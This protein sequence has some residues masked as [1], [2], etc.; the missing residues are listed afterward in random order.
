M[1]LLP[2]DYAVRNLGRSTPRLVAIASGSALV[3]LLIVGAAAFARGMNRSLTVSRDNA[4]ILLLSS[5]SEESLERSQ[6][7]PAV[8]G[9]AAAGIPGIREALGIPLVSPE[10]H[11]AMI[12]RRERESLEELRALFRGVTPTA[13]LVHP[14][15]Q[16]VEGSPPRPGQQELLVG[17]LASAKMGVP[18]ADLA[19]GRQ[20]WFDDRPWTVAGRFRAPGTV[21]DAEIWLPLADLQVA[22]QNDKLSVVVATLGEGAEF[23]DADAW[24]K[25]RLDLELSALSEA[26]Y[27]ASLRRFY[28]PVQ[29]MVWATATLMALAGLLG[30]LNTLY[31]AFA[32]RTRELGTLQ[33][34]GFPR[35]A[36]LLSLVQ[37]SL[38]ATGAG[39]L[40]GCALGRLLLHGWA[41]RFSMGVFELSVD[42]SA[43]L[44][45]LSA[46]ALVGF[47]GAIPPALRALRMPIA[48]ALKAS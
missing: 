33:A 24:A 35:R 17:G 48:S 9:H 40:I 38:L 26:E 29:A 32:S 4:N 23:A 3:T 19:I 27:Y 14:R 47:L 22:S 34:L 45:G 39:A 20:L 6:I 16:I 21:M 30:G 46:G 28:G 44:A 13:F 2:F 7:S 1:R 15:V 25:T 31:A 18:D 5:G 42:A 8:A 11:M 41:A 37:E 10:I 43:I 36:I 12:V